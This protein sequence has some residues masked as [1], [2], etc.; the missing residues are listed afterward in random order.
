MSLNGVSM[1][2]GVVI[3]IVIIRANLVLFCMLIAI[4][5]LPVFIVLIAIGRP[6]VLNTGLT[7]VAIVGLSTL[8]WMAIRSSAKKAFSR[9]ERDGYIVWPSDDKSAN[10]LVI[11]DNCPSG[12]LVQFHAEANRL[13]HPARVS[14]LC[15][16]DQQ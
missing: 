2:N 16:T 14:H 8:V 13:R 10:H 9:A 4:A 3:T 5:E 7:K 12:W 1:S 15:A 6:D 11:A